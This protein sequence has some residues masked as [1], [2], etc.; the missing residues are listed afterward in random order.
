MRKV[1]KKC[2]LRFQKWLHMWVSL[3]SLT[4]AYGNSLYHRGNLRRRV[5]ATT[6]V[7]RFPIRCPS[8]ELLQRRSHERMEIPDVKEKEFM[9]DESFPRAYGNSYVFQSV[10]IRV[11]VAP[12]SVW[13]F[14]E[15]YPSGSETVGHFHMVRY[16]NW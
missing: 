1:N 12:T 4:R 3:L 11:I 7:W 2:G 8:L 14:P 13:K 9:T 15:G 10:C 5:V 6:S 16:L